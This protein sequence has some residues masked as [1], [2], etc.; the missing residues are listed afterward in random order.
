M[1]AQRVLRRPQHLLRQA[2]TAGGASAPTDGIPEI[3]VA[4]HANGSLLWLK[5][6]T[7]FL[8]GSLSE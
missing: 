6:S 5:C 3:R 1:A 8:F 7:D 2:G 4:A